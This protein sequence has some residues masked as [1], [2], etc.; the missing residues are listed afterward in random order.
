MGVPCAICHNRLRHKGKETRYGEPTYPLEA[1]LKELGIAGTHA[2]VSCV[3]EA[4]TAAEREA[5]R[6]G[7]PDA[8][9]LYLKKAPTV[10]ARDETKVFKP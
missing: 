4:R 9:V 5:S 8:S 3:V 7:R 2:H 6:F 10:A 1:S